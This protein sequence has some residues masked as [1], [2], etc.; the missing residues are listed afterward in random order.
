M[1]LNRIIVSCFMIVLLQSVGAQN[2]KPEWQNHAII[3]INKEKPHALFGIFDRPEDALNKDAGESKFQQSLNGDWKFK[4]VKKAGERPKDFYR[5]NYDVSSWDEIEVPAN[6]Q[7]KGYGVPIYLNQPYCFPNNPPYIPAEYSPVGSYRREFEVPQD[8]NHREVF[9][10]FEGVKS[11]FYIWIN[12]KKVGYSQG[13]MTPAEFNI[14]DYLQEGKNVLAVEVYRWSDGS[15][16]EDQDAWDLS[17]IYRDVYLFSTPK[18]FM[19]D[20]YAVTGLDKSY[21]D[22]SLK[23]TVD[24][25]NSA[26]KAEAYQVR[27]ALYNADNTPVHEGKGALEKMIVKPGEEKSFEANVEL[28]NPL[29]WSAETPHLYKLYCELRQGDE[30]IE[31]TSIPI[32]FKSVEIVGNSFLVNGERIYLKGVNR[33]E[34]DP[35]RGNA[36]SRERMEEDVKLLKQYNI[37]AV[38][39]AHYPSHPYFYELCDRY[40]IY[41]YDETNLETHE[42]RFKGLPGDDPIWSAACVDRME[43]LMHRDKNHACVIMWS[44][45]NES[46]KG[47]T[48]VDM[49]NAAKAIDPI[50]P[51]SYHD[52]HN[53]K[54][55]LRGGYLSEIFD[56]R[57]VSSDEVEAAFTKKKA[58]RGSTYEE[59][60]SRPYILTEYAH[61]MGNSMGGY[62]DLWEVFERYPSIQGGFIWDWA[63]QGL[64]AHTDDG[65]PFWAYGGD[66]GPVINHSKDKRYQKYV[67]N[68]L[69]NGLVTPDRKASPGLIEVKKAHQ[70]VKLLPIVNVNDDLKIYNKFF[71]KDLGFVDAHWELLANGVS[72]DKGV[73]KLPYVAPQATISMRAPYVDYPFE[74]DKEYFFKLSF[75]LNEACWWAPE[76]HVIAW[77]Q[78][79]LPV[80]GCTKNDEL[81]S[82]EKLK[83]KEK[84]NAYHFIGKDY[85]AT[86]DKTTGLLSSYAV[87]GKEFMKGDLTPNFWRAMTDNDANIKKG[88]FGKWKEA[89]QNLSLKS[90]NIEEKTSAHVTVV[91][92]YELPEVAASY[93]VTYTLYGDGKVDVDWSLDAKA[94][95]AKVIP[96]LGM[97]MAVIPAMNKVKWYGRGPHESYW[98]RKESAAI[99]TYTAKVSELHHPYVMAQENGN[100]TDVRWVTF[101]DDAGNGIR[102]SSDSSLNF[103]AWSYTQEDLA[104]A[105]H[106]VELPTR[107][108]TTINIDY[109]QMGLGCK[110]SWGGT[111]L[112]RHLLKPN[113]YEFK[114]TIEPVK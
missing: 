45:G 97:S 59:T 25:K 109:Q 78:Y 57:Y 79:R 20:I 101:V 24:V 3:G 49:K 91:S 88:F 64:I 7:M 94:A 10:H 76:G 113:H 51:I 90:I 6:W 35:Y 99:G 102:F 103:S 26:D 60:L 4:W 19:R 96:R 112:K 56:Q 17:G 42:N 67:G 105:K 43:R 34:M 46:G 84:D 71:F 69:I 89:T 54:D 1:K 111:P 13:S 66:F 32:G 21:K 85:T 40:G 39:T 104:Q 62:S 14:T 86:I 63:D 75:K 70:N 9:I 92:T 11:A 106:D 83:L 98:D 37:N 33:P 93:S 87:N 110:N 23:L 41:V 2:S 47:R 100:R 50:T 28:V 30:V 38:R 15:Y 27:Y 77:D 12:G 114:F 18:A 29:K 53:I 68:F 73:L 61:S 65:K 82:V 52:V 108:F 48:F 58:F 44:M 22:G 81:V 74:A 31:C 8:W 16:L 72:V 95:K 107:D 5:S 80:G 36:I 55:S